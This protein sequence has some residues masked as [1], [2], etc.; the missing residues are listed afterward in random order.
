MSKPEASKQRRRIIY[1]DDQTWEALRSLAAARAETISEV[2]RLAARS[3]PPGKPAKSM[4]ELLTTRA[5]D[6]PAF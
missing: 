3:Q 5:S 4:T 6:E 1:M 2:I